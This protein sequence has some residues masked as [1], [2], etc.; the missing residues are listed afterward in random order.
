LTRARGSSPNIARNWNQ[1]CQRKIHSSDLPPHDKRRDSSRS[2]NCQ[3]GRSPFF[4][5]PPHIQKPR[6]SHFPLPTH[7]ISIPR[8]RP[9]AP[10]LNSHHTHA[11][12]IATHRLSSIATRLAWRPRCGY[13]RRLASHPSP[14]HH[15]ASAPSL[16]LQPPPCSLPAPAPA[17]PVL[18]VR[19]RRRLRATEQQGPPLGALHLF[20][21]ITHNFGHLV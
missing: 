1:F 11:H 14:T 21:L 13:R 17:L 20:D 4:F 2:R 10:H 19:R 9:A 7:H 12:T 8:F 3:R 6:P 15:L 18:R 5:T 16:P